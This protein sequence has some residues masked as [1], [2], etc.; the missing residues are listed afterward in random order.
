MQIFTKAYLLECDIISHQ[1]GFMI[2]YVLN[3]F[4]LFFKYFNALE[5][6]FYQ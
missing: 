4:P 3:K 6:K 1:W 5:T 2:S